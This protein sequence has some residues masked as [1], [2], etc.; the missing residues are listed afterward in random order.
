MKKDKYIMKLKPHFEKKIWGWEKWNLSCHRDGESVIENGI[1]KGRKLSE[2][3]ETCKILIKVIKTDDYLSVQVHP[4]DDYARK[5]EN[6]N[7]KTECW[8]IVEADEDAKI[9]TGIKKKI[10]KEAFIEK[11]K[12]NEIEK[13]LHSINVKQ[14]D[15]IYIPSGTV[16]AI[17]KGIKLIEVQ[18]SSNVTYRLYDWGRKREMHIKKSLDVINFSEN[19]ICEKIN[20]F[21][22]ISTPYFKIEK[23]HVKEEMLKVSENLQSY[24]VI[25]GNGTITSDSEIIDIKSEDTVFI[26]ESMKYYL[27]GEMELI[28]VDW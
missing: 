15:F 3:Y 27:K 22:M 8:Y 7:G 11:I 4:G 26:P 28:K 2:I 12:K 13:C 14:G 24:T 6:D 16:H 1:Y 17:G 19:R 9:I 23:L 5:Y 21:K 20:D 25:S 18:Q 10:D